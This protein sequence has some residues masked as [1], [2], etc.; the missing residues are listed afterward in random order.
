[1]AIR[2]GLYSIINEKYIADIDDEDSSSMVADKSV[3]LGGDDTQRTQHTVTVICITDQK[4]NIG[5]AFADIKAKMR[6]T[7]DRFT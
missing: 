5:K 1:M 7:I 3:F 4:C 6:E 2:R